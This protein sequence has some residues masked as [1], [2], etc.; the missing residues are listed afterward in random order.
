MNRGAF[1]STWDLLSAESCS[2][3][4]LPFP[5]SVTRLSVLH[6]SQ[7]FGVQDVVFVEDCG[8]TESLVI[9]SVLPSFIISENGPGS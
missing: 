7:H 3:T 1:S 5:R 2:S 8:F 9:V 6:G 4:S